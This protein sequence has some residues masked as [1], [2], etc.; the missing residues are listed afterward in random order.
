MEPQYQIIPEF[1]IYNRYQELE[2]REKEKKEQQWEK[3]LLRAMNE[4]DPLRNSHL[5]KQLH[6]CRSCPKLNHHP[7]KFSSRMKKPKSCESDGFNCVLQTV[8]ITDKKKHNLKTLEF[9]SDT[10][11]HNSDQN[12]LSLCVSC[13][14]P[15]PEIA[16]DDINRDN[17]SRDINRK[18]QNLDFIDRTPSPSEKNILH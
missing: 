10:K 2:R 18:M 11:K 15:E 9:V 3:E 1:R 17:S 13:S 4:S 8:E 7:P 6:T 16:T 12:L 14:K 5:E